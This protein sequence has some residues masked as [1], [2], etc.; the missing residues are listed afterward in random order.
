[1]L[2]SHCKNCGAAKSDYQALY[3]DPCTDTMQKGQA[4]HKE[5]NPE[6]TQSEILYAGR[7]ALMTT[8]HNAHKNFVDPRLHSRYAPT[9]KPIPRI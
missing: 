1:M 2:T 4:A 7:A 3:C 8:A 6:A 5:A 9:N